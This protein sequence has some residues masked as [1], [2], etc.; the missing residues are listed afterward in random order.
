M[1]MEALPYFL[2]RA[3]PGALAALAGTGMP[4]PESPWNH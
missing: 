4:T 1:S 2:A 3:G